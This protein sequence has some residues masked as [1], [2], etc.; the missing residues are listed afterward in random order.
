MSETEKQIYNLIRKGIQTVG[1]PGKNA[2]W[3]KL[4]RMR[5][6][7]LHWAIPIAAFSKTPVGHFA[8]PEEALHFVENCSTLNTMLVCT[9]CQAEIGEGNVLECMH[10]CKPCAKERECEQC[11]DS[12]ELVKLPL[13]AKMKTICHYLATN[14]QSSVVI[15]STRVVFLEM[16]AVHLQQAKKVNPAITETV[17]Q[18]TGKVPYKTRI[19]QLKEC[20]SGHFI[21][22]ATYASLGE[23]VQL[24]GADTVILAD[25]SWNPVH[26]QQAIARVWRL[27]RMKPV[28]V[29]YLEAVWKDSPSE[30]VVN[31][32]STID[33]QI[34]E[35]VRTKENLQGDL[36]NQVTTNI[37]KTS[38]QD[39]VINTVKK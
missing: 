33:R 38:S 32:Y 15:F 21:A 25:C 13:S 23:G 27:G 20:Q 11:A 30:H 31:T 5:E 35:V 9:V 19:A 7:L 22:L 10:L 1:A 6:C 28:K 2:I 17:F 36:L 39:N 26:V 29:T 3:A 4:N 12:T 16:L 34:S 37:L 18:F 24:I 8:T 14:P